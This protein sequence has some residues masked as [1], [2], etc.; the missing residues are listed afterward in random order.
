MEKLGESFKS[1]KEFVVDFIMDYYGVSLQDT[2]ILPISEYPNVSAKSQ[3]IDVSKLQIAVSK[4]IMK[5]LE[6]IHGAGL[7]GHNTVFYS[8]SI[9]GF[10]LSDVNMLQ[11]CA[12]EFGHI[13]TERIIGEEWPEKITYELSDG[14][15]EYVAY[16][17]LKS[18]FG[19]KFKWYGDKKNLNL[20]K[21]ILSE[22]GIIDGEGIIN[23]MKES[24]DKNK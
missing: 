17:V 1:N 6:N 4:L 21:K 14:F 13:L 18:K 16:Q 23:F 8:Q 12:H 9:L 22:R 15:A 10:T 20:F 3:K 7:A 2:N 19:E 11:L 24:T 5:V